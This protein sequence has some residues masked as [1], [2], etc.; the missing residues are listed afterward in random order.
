MK[1][2][3]ETREIAC[4]LFGKNALMIG[5]I[6]HGA[7]LLA[8]L[9]PVS[10]S[11]I[12]FGLIYPFY[13]FLFITG[14]YAEFHHRGSRPFGE[15][16]F[17][18]FS[19]VALIPL[20]G[21]IA[22]LGTL[23]VFGGNRPQGRWEIWGMVRSILGMRANPLIVVLCI[24]ILFVLFATILYQYD[25]YFKRTKPKGTDFNRE[26]ALSFLRVDKNRS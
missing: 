11:D 8:G 10:G 19:V 12:F 22:A 21:P 4:T 3:N 13:W 14:A 15:G 9:M 6:S 7:A 23:Y 2:L 1:G 25:P 18:L 24:V 20:I 5:L 16:R 26:Q 17:Y